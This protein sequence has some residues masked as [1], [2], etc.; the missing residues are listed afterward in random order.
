[1][2]YKLIDNEWVGA[3]EVHFPDGQKLTEKNK[4]ETIDGWKWFSDEPTEVPLNEL[5]G[6]FEVNGL[7]FENPKIEL[8][9]I[10]DNVKDK[11]CEVYVNLNDSN[12][13]IEFKGFEYSESW[14]DSEVLK[15]VIEQIGKFKQ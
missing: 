1:M 6:V 12:I 4:K 5:V 15:W 13:D 2:F 10:I 11:V 7:E 14:E 8:V 9:K 3:K